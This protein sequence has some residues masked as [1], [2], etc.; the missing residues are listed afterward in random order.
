M[1]KQRGLSHVLD[2]NRIA[3]ERKG[4]WLKKERK[5]KN[6]PSDARQWYATP[7]K[8]KRCSLSVEEV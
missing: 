7:K 3:T 2:K 1:K 4:F 6:L 5:R 8:E